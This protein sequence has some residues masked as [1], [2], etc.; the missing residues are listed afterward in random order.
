MIKYITLQFTDPEGVGNRR[1]KKEKYIAEKREVE[2]TKQA[3][4]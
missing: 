2:V 4:H 3:R 1:I